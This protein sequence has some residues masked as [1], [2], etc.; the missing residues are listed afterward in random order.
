M[1]QC[2]EHLIQVRRADSK[3]KAARLLAMLEAMVSAGEPPDISTLAR[4]AGVSRRF[5]YDH[6]ELRAE[7]ARGA[8]QI[9]DRQVGAV[10]A[11]ARTTTASLRADL[12][13]AKARGHRLEVELSSLRHRLGELM[14]HE[15]I[16]E[17]GVY[18]GPLA[19]GRTAEL[20]HSLFNAEEA[21]VHRTEELESARQINRELMARLNRGS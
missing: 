5:V 14:G 6:P 21:L 17:C 16:E 4:R 9:V 11:N 2:P 12:E 1:A 3:A 19:S 13:N 18:E 8:S 10:H 20:E 7:I 15:I